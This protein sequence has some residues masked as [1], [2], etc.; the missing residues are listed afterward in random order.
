MDMAILLLQDNFSG[1]II[2]PNLKNIWVENFEANLT[3][4]VQPLDQ[5]IIHC[6]KGHYW[7][8]FIHRAINLYDQGIAPAKIY[9]I[10]Q[11]EVMRIAESAWQSV[12]TPSKIAG[13]K[14]GFYWKSKPFHLMLLS[15]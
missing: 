12:D 15:H 3:T 1:H 8:K 9:E 2:P 6:F 11:L 10:N 5:G 13:I 4:H 7:G 14:L